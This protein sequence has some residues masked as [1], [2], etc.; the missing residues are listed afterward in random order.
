MCSFDSRKGP[1]VNI[2]CSPRLSMTVAAPGD[3]RPPAK[4]PVLRAL[5]R[6]RPF[7]PATNA[8]A[9]QDDFVDQV[10]VEQPADQVAAALHLQFTRWHV[11]GQQLR[12]ALRPDKLRD[13]VHDVGPEGASPDPHSLAAVRA[14]DCW[15]GPVIV[16]EMARRSVRSGWRFAGDEPEEADE[17]ARS[18]QPPSQ[19]VRHGLRV[20]PWGANSEEDGD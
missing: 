9:P 10:L 12:R 18:D 14:V 20:L 7:A 4:S 13:L 16:G 11:A 1:S 5:R 2:A 19:L 17:V 15:C 8:P 3:P 6:G